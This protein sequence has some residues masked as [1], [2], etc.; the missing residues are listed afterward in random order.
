MTIKSE[1]VTKNE[2]R[3]GADEFEGLCSILFEKA[4]DA[5]FI[6]TENENIIRVNEKACQLTGYSREQLLQKTTLELK[7]I[8][9]KKRP[10]HRIYSE[11]QLHSRFKFED[12][13]ARH[14]GRI[15]PVEIT[16]A[17][18]EHK[19]RYLFVSIV[20]DI[21]ERKLNEQI[22]KEKE[23]KYRTIFNTTGTAMVIIDK[24]NIITLVNNEF[25]K[26]SGYQK[27]EI[28]N[29]KN[30][31]EF[32][33]KAE[34]K[35]VQVFLKKC[36]RNKKIKP[37]NYEFTFIDKNNHNIFVYLTSEQICGNKQVVISLLNI[38]QMKKTERALKARE[39]LYN[40]VVNSDNTGIMLITSEGM[41]T[42]ANNALCKSLSYKPEEIIGRNFQEFKLAGEVTNG[43]VVNFNNYKELILKNK[44]NKQKSFIISISTLTSNM[45]NQNEIMIILT[46]ITERKNMEEALAIEQNMISALIDNIPDTIYFKDLKGRFIK[47]NKAQARVL[48][49]AKP[50]HAVGKTDFDFFTSDHAHDA[51]RDEQRI[52]E[53]G[54][55]LVGKIEK[56]RTASGEF[57][58]VSATKIPLNIN[59]KISGIV[60]ISRDITEITEIS[61]ELKR[62]NEELDIA[63][64][65]AESATV[66]KSNFLANMSHEIRTPMNGVIGMTNLL[67]E[68]ELGKE[69]REYLETI[70]N[71]GNALLVLINDILDF[72]KIESGKLDLE[73]NEFNLRDRI[74]ESLDLQAVNAA[75]KGIELAYL[76]EDNTPTTLIGDMVRL[77][78]IINN[79]LSN[80]VKFTKEGEVTINVAAKEL[81][82]R[83][84]QF[85][86][87]IRDTGIGIPPDR[88]DRLFKSFSQVDS[89]TT[90]KYGGT[91]LGLAI[92][93]RLC[94]L[95]EGEMWVESEA[96][97]GSTFFFTIKAQTV[98]PKPKIYLRSANSSLK[99][100]RILIVDDN[101]TNRRILT[102]MAK[103]WGMLPRQAC[104]AREALDLLN[105]GVPLDLIVLDMQMPEMDGL[106][107]AKN[108]RQIPSMKDIP[109]IM[110]TSIGWQE[111]HFKS[112][113]LNFFSILS[114]PVKQNQYYNTLLSIF[115]GKHEPKEK[116]LTEVNK[117]SIDPNM[118]EWLPLNILVA[119]D[120]AIN[121][122]LIYRILKKMGYEPDIVNN[123]L[124]ALLAIEKKEYDVV[125]MDVQMPEMDGIEATK[126]ICNKI[127]PDDR[128]QIIAMTANVMQG[129]KEK[130][131]EAG[132]DD[133]IGKPINVSELTQVLCKSKISV[134]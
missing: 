106:E 120:N 82:S 22:L 117:N 26:L 54:V 71:G 103:N 73:Y 56:I 88:M 9:G 38:T 84:Y 16:L 131:L 17:S 116:P 25:E 121:Q 63:L 97:I 1:T 10:K 108:I 28:E 122:K 8:S 40:A 11:P 47:I 83:F 113:G 126:I 30:W 29:I 37:G 32:V 79:L 5:I 98:P 35:Q 49:L 70:R 46:D 51:A 60:G 14:D 27:S 75:H 31:D 111:A 74:E 67:L 114:K 61:D 105:K 7:S 45:H 42:Y 96:G 78:Q 80:A 13:I 66:A 118:S 133:Y 132:M 93:K 110:L 39:E 115:K 48:G 18:V 58:W 95:M 41:I 50:E 36:F 119:E 123:G 85:T 76:I 81:S 107:L 77:G 53:E 19:G 94:E 3:R 129:D 99:D 92:S 62:K 23:E 20:R 125:L 68:T 15:V 64:A 91:G 100:K 72:S 87:A 34:R 86:F 55:P 33:L 127:P 43:D 44:Y 90:R 59:G 65:K 130:C 101:E 69:Q 52:I 24:N 21:T 57:R 104:S 112:E 102:I 128:P 4:N 89:S 124:E 2:N 6:E 12:E 109:L 134:N